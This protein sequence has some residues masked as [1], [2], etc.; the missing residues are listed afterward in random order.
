MLLWQDELNPRVRC[1]F[2]NVLLLLLSI[3]SYPPPLRSDNFDISPLLIISSGLRQT[4]PLQEGG[5]Q[6]N[7]G[8]VE[9]RWNGIL[10]QDRSIQVKIV[11]TRR[12][13]IHVHT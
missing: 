2:G 11:T 8:Q 1:A 4:E 12:K 10:Q 3:V 9:Q 13:I 7:L 5:L 6:D